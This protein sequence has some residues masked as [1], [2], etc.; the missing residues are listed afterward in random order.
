MCDFDDE[1]DDFEDDGFDE[2]FDD[3]APDQDEAMGE[4]EETDTDDCSGP[5]WQTIAF[6]GAWSEENAEE[7]QRRERIRREVL[8][9][10][11]LKSDFD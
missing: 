3:I 11:Y 9:K 1:F 4:A 7:K 2:P 10:D 8:G 6:L 5:G